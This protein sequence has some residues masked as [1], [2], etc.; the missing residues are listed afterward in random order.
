MSMIELITLI[1]CISF[2]SDDSAK[3]IRTF[4]AVELSV[5]IRSWMLSNK[6]IG[7]NGTYLVV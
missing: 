1:V 7:L 5:L 2:P 3:Q 6:T 4:A